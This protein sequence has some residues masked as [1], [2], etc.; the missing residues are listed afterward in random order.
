MNPALLK[1]VA[2]HRSFVVI[3]HKE[4]D[5]DCIGSQLAL[6]SALTRLGKHCQTVN[7]GPFERT[8]IAADARRFSPDVKLDRLTEPIGA[9][10]V[11]C[12]TEDRIDRI[13]AQIAKLPCAV[14]D[15]HTSGEPFG[16]VRYIDSSAPATTL[17]ILRL[18]E[19]LG[20]SPTAEEAQYLFFGLATDTGFFRFLDHRHATVLQDAARLVECGASPNET[21]QWM[22]HGKTLESRLLLARMLKRVESFHGGRFMIT[23]QTAADYRQFG[24]RRD[25]DSLHSLL[26]T[27]EGVELIGVIRELPDGTG[28]AVSLR[29]T[30]AIDVGRLAAEFGGGGHQKAAGFFRQQPLTVTRAE[31]Q[32]RFAELAEH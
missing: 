25:T 32:S 6:T 27:I 31:L 20:L 5:G 24:P 23:Y 17:L 26:L 30:T 3:G 18:I 21:Y 11:D 29:T 8:E 14:I 4:P 9:I 1:F 22:Y 12:S 2:D 15:H 13:A 7:V 19:G 10:V 16:D 28:C